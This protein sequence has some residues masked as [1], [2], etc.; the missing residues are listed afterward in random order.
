MV[1]PMLFAVTVGL[2]WLVSVG[3]AQLRAVDAAREAARSLARGDPAGEASGRALRVAP[4][5]ASVDLAVG[6][7]DVTASV[8]GWVAGPGGLF[9]F[10]PRVELSAT[11][12]AAMEESA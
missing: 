2:I 4:D 12:V 1:I 5:G 3:V 7:E 6:G 9:S 8:Q 10:L 11:A